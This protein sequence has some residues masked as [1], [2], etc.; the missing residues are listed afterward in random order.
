MRAGPK[1]LHSCLQLLVL[2]SPCGAPV[3]G[4]W[5]PQ[6]CGWPSMLGTWDPG[7][8]PVFC[9]SSAAPLSLQ[10]RN[11]KAACQSRGQESQV[12][13]SSKHRRYRG[14]AWGQGAGGTQGLDPDTFSFSTRSSVCRLSSREKIS[15]QDLSKERRP[16]GAGGPPIQDDD[17]EREEGPTGEGLGLDPWV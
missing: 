1:R 7:G 8:T 12:S 15:L 11:Q 17:D 6:L 10:L 9:P 2:C 5:P 16:G 13:S 3:K 4:A 14:I